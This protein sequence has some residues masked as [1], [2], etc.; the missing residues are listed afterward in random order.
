MC[1]RS[2]ST[3]PECFHADNAN[4]CA[5]S[6]SFWADRA[7]FQQQNL[8]L[9]LYCSFCDL[10]FDHLGSTLTNVTRDMEQIIHAPQ[11]NGIMRS[12]PRPRTRHEERSRRS[13]RR[14]IWFSL[15]TKSGMRQKET[16]QSNQIAAKDPISLRR[17]PG[18]G[19]LM[20]ANSQRGRPKCR[21]ESS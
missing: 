12:I 14:R 7:F 11:S 10:R 19:A 1:L 5:L 9:C 8:C 13:G 16:T 21:E 3:F 4:P 17:Q 2:S 6:P 20:P 15:A 18:P